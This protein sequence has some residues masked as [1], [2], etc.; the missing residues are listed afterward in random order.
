M[1][2][3]YWNNSR[4]DSTP[5]PEQLAEAGFHFVGGLEQG[6]ETAPDAQQ[7]RPVFRQDATKCFHCNTTLHSWEADDDVWVEHAKWSSKC[8]F[9]IAQRGL[10]FVRENTQRQNVPDMPTEPHFED[11]YGDVFQSESARRRRA[12]QRLQGP[13]IVAASIKTADL[14]R[15]AERLPDQDDDICQ[16]FDDLMKTIQC[17][18]CLSARSS[19]LFLPC[20]HISVCPECARKLPEDKCPICRKPIEHQIDAYIS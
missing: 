8:G 16:R 14:T 13:Q 2:T 6:R 12:Q 10:E 5:R 18:V 1:G 9:L 17:K 20:S 19:I 7:E 11:F 4:N 15:K 3:E